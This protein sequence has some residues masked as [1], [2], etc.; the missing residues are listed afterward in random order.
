MAKKQKYW[1]YVIVLTNQGPVFLTS[2]GEGK[3]AYWNKDEQPKELSKEWAED[4]A[5]GLTINGHSAFMVTTKYEL[6]HQPYRYSIGEF[7]WVY[8][9]DKETKDE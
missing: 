1:Y 6:T 5:F 4:I 9:E 7:E 2:I 3:T 8:K